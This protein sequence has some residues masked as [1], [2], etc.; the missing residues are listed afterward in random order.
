MTNSAMTATAPSTP[1]EQ[2]APHRADTPRTWTFTNKE[3]RQSTTVTCMPGCTLDHAQANETPTHPHDIYC[4]MDGTAAELPLYGPL[5]ETSGPE[6]FRVLAWQ[7]NVNPFSGKIAQRLPHVN[8]EA[9]DDHWIEVLDPD[10]LAS[11]IGHVQKQVDSLRTAHAELV[12]VR[13]DYAADQILSALRE[14]K[15]EASA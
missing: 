7:I 11:V 9:I 6:D 10:A 4:Q 15:P 14:V 8:I 1:T 3:T 2:R 12:R 5:C 13:A